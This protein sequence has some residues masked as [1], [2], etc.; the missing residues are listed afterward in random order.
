MKEELKFVVTVG[1]TMVTGGSSVVLV[2]YLAKLLGV[3]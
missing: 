2:F 3:I 1:L